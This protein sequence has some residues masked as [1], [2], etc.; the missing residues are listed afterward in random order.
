MA[1]CITKHRAAA[2]C[3]EGAV[4]G[5]SEQARMNGV[6][7]VTGAGRGIGAAVALSAAKRGYD[8]AV[9]YRSDERAALSIVDAIRAGG[10]RAIALR[11]DVSSEADVMRLFGEVDSFGVLA[12]LVNNAGTTGG[13]SRVA[14]L[15][16]AMLQ[17]V[18]AVNVFGP[19]YASREAVRRMSTQWGGA[20]GSIVNVSSRQATIGG[21]GEWVHYAATKGALETMT[22]G[23]AL[24]VAGEGVRVNA[25]AAGVVDTELHAT[26]GD[27]HRAQR[28]AGSV[29]L[30]RAATAHEIAEAIVWLASSAASY[31]TGTIVD[32]SGGR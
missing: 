32:V 31:V 24:E 12:A 3:V 7:L 6:M 2:R 13:F 27:P 14:D 23:L 5:L 30:G 16:A 29:P 22:R 26:A 15:N 9:N 4:G 10:G 18:F 20:G 1:L 25:V 11:A 8:I 28:M 21:A 17:S 19:F